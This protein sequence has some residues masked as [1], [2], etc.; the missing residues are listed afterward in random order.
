MVQSVNF[1]IL[2]RDAKGVNEREDL[3]PTERSAR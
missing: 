2:N 1:R 3:G